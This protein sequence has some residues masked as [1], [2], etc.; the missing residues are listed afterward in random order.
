MMKTVFTTLTKIKFLKTCVFAAAVLI[1]L[2][3]T[4]KAYAQACSLVTGAS[5]MIQNGSFESNT[6]SW[7]SSNGNLY[8][9]SG[10]QVCGSRNGYLSSPNNGTPTWAFTEAA[11][12]PEGTMLKMSGYFGTHT[13]GQSCSPMIRIAYYDNSWNLI[14]ADSKNVT[15]NVDVAPY[16]A[17]LY[18]INSK[19]PANT[20]HIRFEIRIS[21][22]YMKI[23]AVSVS[24][25]NIS[26][27]VN[28]ISFQG[29]LNN[30]KV[31]LNWKTASEVNVN[32]FM[33]ERSF[34]GINFS[35]AGMVFA[36]GNSTTDNSYALSDNVANVTS[37]VVYYRLRSVDNDSKSQLSETRIIRISK[38]E[39][40]SITITTY[41]NPVASDLRITIPA[42]WQNRKVM[43]EVVNLNGQVAKKI[44]TANSSQ[45][46]NVNVSSLSPGMYVVRVSCEGE[47][48]QQKIVKH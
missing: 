24:E 26:L 21:C 29:M 30:N 36:A 8:T 25:T 41:P 32:Y 43:Y 2:S 28:L 37:P 6:N 11:L 23:D 9:G 27:P 5:N 10:Y 45:T 22:D 34:D 13:A 7:S 15:T 39:L 4:N 33:V 31:E 3:S 42:N 19:V 17:G 48:A 14:S 35:D 47:T 18:V 1:A 38:T 20:S 46:E 16:K 12:K 40:T 44:Q